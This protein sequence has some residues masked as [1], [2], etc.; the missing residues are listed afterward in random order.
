MKEFLFVIHSLTS[1]FL[2]FLA[3]NKVTNVMAAHVVIY[4]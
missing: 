2:L 4:F 1:I 3:I